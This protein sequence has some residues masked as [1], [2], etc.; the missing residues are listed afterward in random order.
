MCELLNTEP[1]LAGNVGSGTVQELADWV[2]YV[3]F[4]AE[5]PMSKLRRDNGREKP[6]NVKYRGVGNE[7]WG[8]G[9]NMKPDH[10][11]NIYRTF[12]TFMTNTPKTKVFKIASGASDDDYQWT[13]TLMK[14]IPLDM[15]GGVAI[16]HYSIIDW[17]KKGSAADFTEQQYFTIMKSALWMEELIQKH[18]AIMDKYDPGKK[19]A[20]VVDEW[21]AWYDVEIGTNP[22]FLFQQNTMR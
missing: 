10:Y 20:M 4:E 8:C 2:Q 18:T 11:A 14:N 5:S 12:A 16:H 7:T 17:N 21:G 9:G 22:G 3:N 6:W 19:V 15:L 1:Y 13:E